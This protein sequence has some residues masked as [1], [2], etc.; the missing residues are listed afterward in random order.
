MDKYYKPGDK[1]KSEYTIS[2]EIGEGRYGIV[3][4]AKNDNDEKVVIKQLKKKDAQADK[5]GIVL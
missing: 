5:K 2:R 3:Y 4:L 1:V